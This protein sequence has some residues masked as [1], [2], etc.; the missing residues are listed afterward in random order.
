MIKRLSLTS[1]LA[2]LFAACT[3]VVSLIA[4]VLFNR[5][6]EAHFMELDQQQLER[7]HAWSMVGTKPLQA[8]KARGF[9]KALHDRVIKSWLQDERLTPTDLVRMVKDEYLV[10]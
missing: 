4:G 8:A 5:A 6:S 1:R 7:M 10:A 2:L 3:A 9:F